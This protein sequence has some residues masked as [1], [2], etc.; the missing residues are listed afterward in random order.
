MTPAAMVTNL[1]YSPNLFTDNNSKIKP[2]TD[3][4][5]LPNIE[6]QEIS[7]DVIP[8]WGDTENFTIGI[9]RQDFRIRSV[10]NN[11]FVMFGSAF[12]DG[13]NSMWGEH[14]H[15]AV[16]IGELF[17]ARND[18]NATVGM[19]TKR[20]GKVTEKIFFYPPNVSDARIDSGQADPISEMEVLDPS[21]YSVYKKEGDF[22]FIVSCNR[23]KIIT[24]DYGNP[25][26]ID[27]DSPNGIFTEFRGFVTLEI[28]NEDVPMNFTGSLGEDSRVVPFRYKLKFP[29]YA[30]RQQSFDNTET[31]NTIN[32]R[33]QSFKFLGGKLYSF[34]KFHGITSNNSDKWSDADQFFTSHQGA[35]G[36]FRKTTVNQISGTHYTE[37]SLT[38]HDYSNAID[39]FRAVGII[40]NGN[41]GNY[42]NSG[43]QFPSNGTNGAYG[44]VFGANWMNLSIYF[45][46]L[47]FQAEGSWRIMRVYS[48][49]HFTEQVE[50]DTN[51]S[52][53]FFDNQQKIAAH[54][55]NTKF[56]ARSDLNWTDIIEVPKN[57]IKS[58]ASV[59]TKGFI[60]TATPLI[61]Q[62]YRNAS[63]IP[64]GWSRAC[65]L[66]NGIGSNTYFYKGLNRSNCIDYVISLG[67]I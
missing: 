54:E 28:T 7:V 20:P 61:G 9:T 66:Y 24:D 5:D 53:F 45:P 25:Q 46:Q 67:L 19:Y 52:F 64:T 1:G 37:D 57:D 3:L 29:Q 15:S 11:T 51:N 55:I 49:D 6:T 56:F 32:W 30:A 62:S 14:D 23:N 12:T 10:L 35:G 44:G 59:A 18:T 58:M 63:K 34:A 60:N 47:G 8:F 41:Y 21:Q 22:V 16:R 42:K 4:N 17:R 40:V 50:D 31:S 38:S 36:F 2:S 65:P 43:Q 13:E 39:P 48:A 26:S 33:K 27:A